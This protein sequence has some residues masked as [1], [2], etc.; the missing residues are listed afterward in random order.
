M[1][2][3][4]LITFNSRT[5]HSRDVAHNYEKLMKSIFYILALS[6]SVISCQKENTT[7][8]IVTDFENRISKTES[9]EYD[10]HYKMKYF[11]SD[12]DTLDFYSNC[13][14]I[15]HKNDT[16]FG[17]SFWIKNDSIDRYYDLENIYII[18]HNSKKITKFFPKKGQD[19]A[20]R[21]NTVSGVL[22][23]YF[24]KPNRLSKYLKDSTIV[25]RLNDTLI[26]KSSFN[27]IEFGFEDELPIEKQ[28]KTFYFN[29][30]S[31]LKDITYSVK[32]QNEWQYNEWHFTNEKYNE[33]ND[34]LLKSELDKLKQNYEIEDYK[35]PNPKEMEPLAIGLNAPEFKGMNFKENDSIIL[36]DYKGKYVILDFWYKD[37]FPCIKAIASLNEL[38][39]KY[40][41]KDLVILGLN[42]FDNKEKNKEKLDEFIKINKMSYPTIFVSNKVTEKYNVRAY[43]T[44]YIIDDKG[45]I[46]YSKVGHS[47]NNEKEIDSLLRKWIK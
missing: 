41:A 6:I 28:R 15:K 10:V 29:N 14:L 43:P 5:N 36:K 23:S 20:I 21:G 45:K 16:I 7:H 25:A 2:N 26:N 24:L 32:F 44:F 35:E 13:R 39:T 42:P 22:D 19:W 30:D 8:S 31:Y 40:T 18:N 3:R 9:W 4:E 37:C 1:L 27:K 17:G 12:E 47:E 46:V 11:S 38:R 33:V 34:E